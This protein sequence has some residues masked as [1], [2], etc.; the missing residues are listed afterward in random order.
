MVVN[1]YFGYLNSYFNN[2]TFDVLDFSFRAIQN[3]EHQL[4]LDSRVEY[5]SF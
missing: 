1:K 4:N 3:F 5:G 2:S